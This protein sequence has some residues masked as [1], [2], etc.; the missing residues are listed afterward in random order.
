MEEV[1]NDVPVTE[2]Q[3][4]EEVVTPTEPVKP[5]EKTDPALLLES[6]RKE[7]EKRKE[8]EAELARKAQ[9]TIVTEPISDEGK[10]LASKIQSLEQK[11]AAKEEDAKLQSLQSTYPVLKDKIIEFENFRSDPSN[12]GMRLE[13]AAKAFLAENDLLVQPT[14]RKG[15]EKDTGGARTVPKTGMTPEEIDELRVNNYREY[16][17]RLR[18]GTLN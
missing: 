11:L 6:L 18:N 1:V 5:G 7:R 3:K 9:E 16:A 2:E 12:A 15:L 14:P 4:A 8:L 10:Y 13:T 17:K